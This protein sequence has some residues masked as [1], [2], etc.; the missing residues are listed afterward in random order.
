ME[1]LEEAAIR[2]RVQDQ[3]RQ[4]KIREDELAK[5]TKDLA[6]AGLSAEERTYLESLGIDPDEYDPVPESPA[7]KKPGL[8]SKAGKVIKPALGPLGFGLTTAAA[9]TTGTA[10][11]QRAEAMGI[12]EPLAKTAGVV[13]GASEFLPVPPSDVAEVQP[14]PFSMRPVERAAAES[15]IVREGLKTTGQLQE[16]APRETRKA[17]PAPI[18]DSFLTMSP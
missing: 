9:I 18:D 3:L 13:A 15:E 7:D 8:L 12:P 1:G 17:A 5:Q 11:R 6:P 16:V 14:D 10:V 4:K 2:R